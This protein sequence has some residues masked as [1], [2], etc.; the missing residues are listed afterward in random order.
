MNP[1]RKKKK[2]FFLTGG[3]KESPHL[4]RDTVLTPHDF[5]ADS[6]CSTSS[7]SPANLTLVIV[8][9]FLAEKKVPLPDASSSA[10]TPR[11]PAA[12]CQ[13]KKAAHAAPSRAAK[14]RKKRAIFGTPM[15]QSPAK[16]DRRGH[17]GITPI[18]VAKIAA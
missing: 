2:L 14:N 3:T 9:A 18:F 8:G 5:T 1:K 4:S 16:R 6:R 11:A 7:L 10:V 13:P 12:A 17:F 15:S